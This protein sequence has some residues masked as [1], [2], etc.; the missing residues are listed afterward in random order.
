MLDLGGGRYA[1]HRGLCRAPME[2]HQGE[3]LP[4]AQEGFQAPLSGRER[5]RTLE[6]RDI[7]DL[8]E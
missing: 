5:I 3:G 4:A 6:A 2:R 8:T 7:F 1:G